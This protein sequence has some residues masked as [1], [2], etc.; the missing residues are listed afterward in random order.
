MLHYAVNVK[1]VIC[2][3][4]A[5]RL[6]IEKVWASRMGSYI[7]ILPGFA[8]FVFFFFGISV[9]MVQGGRVGIVL[10]LG[11]LGLAAGKQVCPLVNCSMRHNHLME[12]V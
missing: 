10:L 4:I 8:F 2:I 9:A 11:L 1:L 3:C 12:G 6:R 7:R 5:F